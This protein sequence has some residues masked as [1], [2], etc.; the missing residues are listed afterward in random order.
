MNAQA[1]GFGAA[2]WE[3]KDE[4]SATAF[5]YNSFKLAGPK[6]TTY[7]GSWDYDH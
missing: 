3:I 6:I 1:K 5:V 7:C 2:R 4:N